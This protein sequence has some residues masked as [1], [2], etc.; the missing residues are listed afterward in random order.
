MTKENIFKNF[1]EDPLLVENRYITAEQAANYKFADPT[2]VKLL[3]MIKI[4]IHNTVDGESDNV[5]SRKIQQYLNNN[6]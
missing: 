5:T 2:G 3:E 1:L 4:A 6:L